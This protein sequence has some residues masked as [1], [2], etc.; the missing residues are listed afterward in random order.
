ME[1]PATVQLF[2][3]YKNLMTDAENLR[4]HIDEEAEKKND[5]LSCPF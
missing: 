1:R 4:M 5:V 3:K 2:T